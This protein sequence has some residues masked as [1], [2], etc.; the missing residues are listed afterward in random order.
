MYFLKN[1]IFYE[2][3]ISLRHTKACTTCECPYEWIFSQD[4]CSKG[5]CIN[6]YRLES[7]KR[8]THTLGLYECK[9]VLWKVPT[10]KVVDLNYLP[11]ANSNKINPSD[12]NQQ[13]NPWVIRDENL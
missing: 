8:D 1:D 10:T 5:N 12:I 11:C 7:L 13:E 2:V 4:A 3:P 6:C 9:Q